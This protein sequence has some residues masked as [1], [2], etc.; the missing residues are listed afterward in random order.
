MKSWLLVTGFGPFPGVPDNPTQALA[1]ALDGTE[2]EGLRVR[3]EVLDTSYARSAA[4]LA[5]IVASEAA[6]PAAAVHF[7]VAVGSERVRIERRAANRAAPG[8]PDVDGALPAPRLQ[9]G[10]DA[11]WTC[12]TPLPVDSIIA[13]LAAEGLAVRPSEDCGRYV[14]NGL[15]LRSLTSLGSAGVPCLFVHV[16]LTGGAIATATAER[17]LRAVVQ[18]LR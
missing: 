14:C 8:R 13:A 10:R 18:T 17:V 3:G 7:G 6:P 1:Q 5:E 4:R 2:L 12:D 16:P 9:P 11:D 15:Y